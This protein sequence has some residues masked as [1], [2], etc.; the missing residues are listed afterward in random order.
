M[1]FAVILSV[2]RIA[3]LRPA[4]APAIIKSLLTQRNL[5]S[6]ILDINL[7]FYDNFR[8][9]YGE[10][11]YWALDDYFFNDLRELTKDQTTIYNRWL[12]SWVEQVKEYFPKWLMISVFTWQAQKFTRDFLT[13]WKQQTDIPVI[14]GG[15]G[16]IKEENGSF[17]SIPTFA[18][19]LKN[20]NLIAHWIR[21]EIET[22]IDA[23]VNNT[24]DANG[25]DT[26]FL[27][28]RSDVNS[29]QF[30]NFDDFDITR[31]H[32]GYQSGVLPMETSRGCVRN[33]MFCDIPTMHGGYRYKKGSRLFEEMIY[34]YKKYHV[35]DYFFHDALCN[36]SVKDF[37]IFNQKLTEYYQQHEL[38]TR[39]LKYSSHYIVRSEKLMP[40]KDFALMSSAGAECMVI[41]VESG[42]DQVKH[43]MRKGFTNSDLD[44]NMKM[45]SKYGIT[46]YFL[47]I[48]GFPTETRDDFEQTLDL[49]KRY[50][51]YV[52]DGTIIGVNLGTT[53]TIEEGTPIWEE[54]PKLNIVGINGNRAQGPD[55]RCETNPT[56]TYKERIMRRIEAQEYA[57]KLGYTFWKG[58]DQLKLLMDKYQ[59]RL[60]KL[61]GVIH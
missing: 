33:C 11:I 16:L 50:Q 40:E 23:I 43:D 27:A 1:M 6:K 55:W 59:S 2:P 42:S 8:K 35:K 45:F 14:I 58:D 54:Y 51:P 26:D 18:H 7:D 28:D 19:E 46:A 32:S 12:V 41:G 48:V 22:T 4:A 29:H 13:V 5:E 30:M 39:H 49:L 60:H 47:M 20:K 24:F 25:I 61:A 53:L 3:A 37:R 56:L 15:Q 36:G 44:Y 52:A 9:Q 57:V 10:E 38:D 31:Y 17:A 21:G 34:Y